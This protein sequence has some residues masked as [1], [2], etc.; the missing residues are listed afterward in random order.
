MNDCKTL[1]FE[2]TP[3]TNFKIQF[4]CNMNTV[5]SFKKNVICNAFYGTIIGDFTSPR[6]ADRVP[7][8]S[9][10]GSA[11]EKQVQGILSTK[12]QKNPRVQNRT[13]NVR[14]PHTEKIRPV[15]KVTFLVHKSKSSTHILTHYLLNCYLNIISCIRIILSLHEMKYHVCL[16]DCPDAYFNSATPRSIFMKLWTTPKFVPFNLLQLVIPKWLSTPNILG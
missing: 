7:P 3:I 16:S 2:K 9:T 5:L 13:K 14:Q 4:L 11:A 6:T 12:D 15:F 8:P 1:Y 10:R